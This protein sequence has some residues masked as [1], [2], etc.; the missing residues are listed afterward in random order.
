MNPTINMP[1]AALAVISVAGIALSAGCG[2]RESPRKAPVT[3]IAI[4]RS[5]SSATPEQRRALLD[6]VDLLANYAR[7]EKALV[8]VWA[9]DHDAVRIS[10]PALV[11]SN[12]LAVKAAI[13]DPTHRA[14]KGTRPGVLVEQLASDRALGEAVERSAGPLRVVILT[15][16][17]ID[18]PADKV[19]L[20]KACKQLSTRFPGLSLR[21]AGIVPELRPDWDSA[22]RTV[23]DYRC[24]T[25]LDSSALVRETFGDRR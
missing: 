5:G 14:P 1:T 2:T 22:A 6:N 4:D 17:G 16:G 7:S 19:R 9:F 21:I 24:A 25:L 11:K 18:D 13:V 23:A 3:V 8:D 12:L 20:A 10:G 15:D